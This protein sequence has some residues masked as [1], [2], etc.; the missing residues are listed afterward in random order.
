MFGKAGQSMFDRG[1]VRRLQD[2]VNSEESLDCNRLQ[3]L[4]VEALGGYG[5][6]IRVQCFV[7]SFRLLDRTN[8]IAKRW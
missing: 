3:R 2:D 6:R 4:V 8:V 7:S 5:S 1:P